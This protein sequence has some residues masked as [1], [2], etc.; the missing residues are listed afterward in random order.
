M[1]VLRRELCRGYAIRILLRQTLR[2]ASSVAGA[3]LDLRY[4]PC[5]AWYPGYL[6]CQYPATLNAYDITIHLHT[7]TIPSTDA[8]TYNAQGYW[9][10]HS[11]FRRIRYATPRGR[12]EKLS[13]TSVHSGDDRQLVGCH[14]RHSAFLTPS[15]RECIARTEIRGSTP[16]YTHCMPKSSSLSST[17]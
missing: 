4:L 17:T 2:S 11:Q 9:C 12:D 10:Y 3:D 7:R 1:R 8:L 13:D 5:I 14:Q 6:K 16:A 15:R